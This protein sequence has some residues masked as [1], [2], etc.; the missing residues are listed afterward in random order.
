MNHLG[1]SVKAP[2]Q[3]GPVTPPLS[4][5]DVAATSTGSSD[6]APTKPDLARKVVAIHIRQLTANLLSELVDKRGAVGV[7]IVLPSEAELN[8]GAVSES[9]LARWRILEQ[10]MLSREWQAPIYFSFE[11]EALASI[12]SR[13]NADPDG[14]ADRYQFVVASSESSVIPSVTVANFHVCQ[15]TDSAW[16]QAYIPPQY[17]F[18]TNSMCCFRALRFGLV[19]MIGLA[20]RCAEFGR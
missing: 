3:T 1:T 17:T 18:L 2:I 8:S 16:L 11:D 13:I 9:D 15:I 7:F 5:E 19:M 20:P 4:E 12:V 10:F 14:S 6:S